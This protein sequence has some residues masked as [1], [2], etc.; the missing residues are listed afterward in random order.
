LAA[1]FRAEWVAPK[2]VHRLTADAAYRPTDREDENM[3][4]RMIA[5]LSIFAIAA[6]AAMAGGIESVAQSAPPLQVVVPPV[7]PVLPVRSACCPG[8]GMWKLLDKQ[9]LITDYKAF[10]AFLSTK[11][12]P[13]H[14][15][16]GEVIQATRPM[17]LG[18]TSRGGPRQTIVDQY[19]A[20]KYPGTTYCETF[21]KPRSRFCPPQGGVLFIQPAPINAGDPVPPGGGYLRSESDTNCSASGVPA[22]SATPGACWAIEFSEQT[23][24]EIWIR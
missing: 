6:T 7:H 1:N 21:T 22:C 15:T 23:V 24:E 10:A 9:V 13:L 14:A 8:T 5:K 17:Y 20:Y 2:S 16:G 12:Y 4:T 18:V 3:K 11:G 19:I